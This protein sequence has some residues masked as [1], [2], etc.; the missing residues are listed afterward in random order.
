MQGKST[1]IGISGTAPKKVD[2]KK[3]KTGCGAAWLG[4]ARQGRVWKN[5]RQ[6]E[7]GEK[8]QV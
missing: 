2:E 7:K 3:I 4:M 8:N 5:L 1:A 6:G